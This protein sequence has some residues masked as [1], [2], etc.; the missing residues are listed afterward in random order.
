MT[1]VE[2]NSEEAV[3][4]E[5]NSQ[6]PSKKSQVEGVANGGGNPENSGNESP[7]KVEEMERG[8]S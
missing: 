8:E 2:G 3:E 5:G 4:Q 1:G 6:S 7:S